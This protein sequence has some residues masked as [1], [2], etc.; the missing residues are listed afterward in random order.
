MTNFPSKVVTMRLKRAH[1]E[2]FGSAMVGLVLSGIVASVFA[3]HASAIGVVAGSGFGLGWWISVTQHRYSV[4]Q[5]TFFME[6]DFYQQIL[7]L[8]KHHPKILFAFT[9]SQHLAVGE[10]LTDVTNWI[11]DLREGRP[12][13]HSARHFLDRHPHF[14]VG[15]LVQLM[16]AVEL[17]GTQDYGLSLDIIQD[18][19]EEWIE[20]TVLVK[21]QERQQRNR[22][23]I[24]CLFALII[25]YFSQSMLSSSGLSGSAS[26]TQGAMVIFLVMIQGTLAATQAILAMRWIEPSEEVWR[27]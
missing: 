13:G 19:L 25:A 17:F 23:A 5:K 24:L 21:Q 11:A 18:D 16:V 4:N 14:V 6:V 8:F 26:L 27:S 9:E 12:L 2:A 1:L 20:D 15:N 10:F 22:I 3:L 7:A